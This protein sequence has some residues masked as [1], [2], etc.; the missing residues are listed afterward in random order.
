MNLSKV[1]LLC[2]FLTIM[3]FVPSYSITAF[4]VGASF[5][6]MLI[7]LHLNR[8]SRHLAH[9]LRFSTSSIFLV[10]ATRIWV[11]I[12]PNLPLIWILTWIFYII[13]WVYPNIFP[14]ISSK[15][16]WDVYNLNNPILRFMVTILLAVMPSPT[17]GAIYGIHLNKIIR[18]GDGGYF[19]V[20]AILFT[21]V[22]YLL[23]FF[24]SFS[25][26]K[27]RRSVKVC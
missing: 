12:A 8:R 1:L 9:F 2:L 17:A 19:A 15:A 21:L 5:G 22:T 6:F 7:I 10:L 16:Y 24:E 23:S 13:I 26:T 4:T 18:F 14:I 11:S 27:S 25:P 20:V 3:T